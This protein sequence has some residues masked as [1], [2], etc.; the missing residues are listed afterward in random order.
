MSGPDREGDVKVWEEEDRWVLRFDPC[1]SGG[2]MFRRDPE[3]KSAPEEP[4]HGVTTARYDWAWNEE[5]V[6]YYCVHCC[7]LQE[8]VPIERLGYPLRVVEPPLWPPSKG[9]RH[10]TW[11]IYK[12]PSLVP[13][14]AYGRVGAPPP[15]GRTHADR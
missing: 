7:Q 10:C 4:P 9:R 8:R 14:E 6:C 12:D 13:D 3:A 2:R 15:A 11:S 5:G 1:G